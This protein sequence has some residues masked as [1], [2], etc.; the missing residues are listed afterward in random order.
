MTA[1]RREIMPLLWST[2][3]KTML[4]R[5]LCFCRGNRKHQCDSR[6]EVHTEKVRE[7]DER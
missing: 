6:R 1:V 5:G 7:T 3:G 2:A 4:A